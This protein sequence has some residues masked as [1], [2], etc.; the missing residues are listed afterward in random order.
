MGK[1]RIRIAFMTDAS[2][3]QLRY[4]GQMGASD[5]V[6]AL[7]A[8]QSG[9]VWAFEDI[10]RLKKKVEDAGL[11]LSIFEAIPV[12][13]RVKLGRPGRDEDID[14]Y[15]ESIRNMGRAGVPILCYNWMTAFNWLRTS[16]TTAV[17]GG[18][19]ATSYN[20]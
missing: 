7:P 16:V 11:S 1:G 19:L 14:N 18:A 10:L 20:H 17:R 12:P 5:V 6:T 4:V 8:G 2:D 9:A 3:S 15:C 13:D